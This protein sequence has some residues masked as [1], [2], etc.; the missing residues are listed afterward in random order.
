MTKLNAADPL[1]EV[2]QNASPCFVAR[3]AD[4]LSIIASLEIIESIGKS[5][6]RFRLIS[7]A[8][9]F[10]TT[11]TGILSSLVV[12]LADAGIWILSLGTHDTDYILLR[13]DQFDAAI[14]ALKDAGHQI[15]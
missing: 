12:P 4:E 7:V 5:V 15:T 3:T 10:G 14:A 13:D 1:P 8:M 6:G 2:I 9:T 11:E